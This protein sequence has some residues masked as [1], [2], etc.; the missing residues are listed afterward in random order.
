MSSRVSSNGHTVY[1]VVEPGGLSRTVV[2]W[3][4]DKAKVIFNGQAYPA[5]W[6]R[7][8]DGDIEV[9]VNAGGV[10]VFSMPD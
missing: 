10:F 7:D 3:E 4:G 6:R 9:S 1:D 5:G 2:P 8:N